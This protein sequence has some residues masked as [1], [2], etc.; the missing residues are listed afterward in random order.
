[1]RLFLIYPEGNFIE[2]TDDT[3]FL[4]IGEHKYGKPIL[5][6]VV[7]PATSLEEGRKAVL[8]SMD[9]TLRSNI[10]CGLP[11]DLL[12]YEADALR[13]TKFVQID[14]QNQYMNMIRNTWGAR[15]KQVFSEIPDPVW[16]DSPVVTGAPRRE[17]DATEPVR[18]P[19]PPTLEV[20]SPSGAVQLVA[21]QIGRSQS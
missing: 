13:V 12:V 1:M 8:I 7:T 2:A 16:R 21:G 18:A 15:L 19:L 4:Q 20:A 10:S 11:L 9:S 14:G 5:D 3:P 6:R 17:I